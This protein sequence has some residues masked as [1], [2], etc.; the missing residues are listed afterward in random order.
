MR[1]VGAENVSYTAWLSNMSVDRTLNGTLQLPSFFQ[2]YSDLVQL[3]L[4]IFPRHQLDY[5]NNNH[6]FYPM[7]AILA[8]VND[9]VDSLNN[10]LLGLFKGD[11]QV[12]HSV[13]S[14]NVNRQNPGKHEVPVEMLQAL[15]PASILPAK[16]KVKLS[17]PLI[18]MRNLS[19]KRG[20]CNDTRVTLTGIRRKVLQVRLPDG[21]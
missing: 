9:T 20:L 3:K 19:I 7:R 14:A 15:Q 6:T 21:R 1:A 17:C 4:A 10:Y 16:L 13:D 5:C 2:V 11:E 8:P 12:L 18:V